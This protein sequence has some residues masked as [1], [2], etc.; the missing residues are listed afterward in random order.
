MA[1]HLLES[2]RLLSNGARNFVDRCISGITANRERTADWIENSLAMVTALAPKI[3]YEA[4]AKIAQEAYATGRTIRQVALEMK[5]LPEDELNRLLDP[6]RQTERGLW[7][8]R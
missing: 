8:D 5:A 6:M 4:A 1:Y 2:I 7:G 3:G